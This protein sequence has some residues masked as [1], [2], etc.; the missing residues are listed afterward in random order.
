MRTPS[1]NTRLFWVFQT[2]GWT[3][4]ALD[5]YLSDPNFFP[6]S[7]IYLCVAF[8][9]TIIYL[10]PLYRASLRRSRRAAF[11][12]AIALTGSITAAV[13]WLII[14]RF[15]FAGMHLM[16]PPRPPWGTYILNT[17]RVA[18]IHHKP[19][20]FLSWSV[21][22][23]ATHFWWDSLE[24]DT[25]A[26]A[27]TAAARESELLALRAQLDPHFLFNS[28]NSV[29]ALI[30][31]NP[32]RATAIIEKI[33]SF[34]R[35]SLAQRTDQQ[36]SL[37]EELSAVSA[38]LEIQKARYED[39]LQV[40]VN[41]PDSCLDVA[42]PHLVLQP[43]V[44][45]AIKHGLQ[46]APPPF[47]LRIEGELD[48]NTLELRIVHPGRLDQALPPHSLG[49]GLSNVRRRMELSMHYEYD[50]QLIENN[51]CVT[52]RLRVRDTDRI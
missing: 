37:R 30:E 16:N 7:F 33:A 9:L 6:A 4:Y 19:F 23:F 52:A 28:L 15:C 32:A 48:G 42:V 5:R 50:F 31:D 21:I 39:D 13:L 8:G 27:A 35:F 14:A 12:I 43:I 10:R 44:E 47:W 22:Y 36:F 41:V 18:L 49:I 1:E 11:I 17:F 20:L 40:T 24:K 25:A 3:L 29:S 45:N 38:Y 51:E 46:T 34:L 26:L 2:C